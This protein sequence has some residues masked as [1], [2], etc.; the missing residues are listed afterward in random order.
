MI[1]H[2]S[3]PLIVYCCYCLRWIDT[4]TN[5][6]PSEVMTAYLGTLFMNETDYTL[7]AMVFESPSE[8]DSSFGERI[9]DK[10]NTLTNNFFSVHLLGDTFQC[11]ILSDK[12][13]LSY[14]R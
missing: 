5:D 12:V 9:T 6:T 3:T 14:E 8:L 13:L 1:I 11:I 2:L 7:G 10:N 4:P